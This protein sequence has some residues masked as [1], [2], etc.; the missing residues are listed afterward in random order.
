MAKSTHQK[1]E[2]AFSVGSI[3]KLKSGGPLMTVE[4][5]APEGFTCVWFTGGVMRRET[6][7]SLLLEPRDPLGLDWGKT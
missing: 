6:F 5:V 3:V 7:L 1:P 2:T 4:A